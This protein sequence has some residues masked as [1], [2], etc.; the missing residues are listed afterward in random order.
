M[1]RKPI[2]WMVIVFMA[3]SVF[4][5]P[6]AVLAE[7]GTVTDP[8][9]TQESQGSATGEQSGENGG[10]T[11]DPP[12]LTEEPDQ[13]MIQ[14]PVVQEVVAAEVTSSQVFGPPVLKLKSTAKTS[15]KLKW[16]VVKDAKGYVIYR[17]KGKKYVKIKTIKKAKITSYTNKKLKKNKT[18]KYRIKAYYYSDDKKVYSKYSKTLSAKTKSGKIV[19]SAGFWKTNAGK[20]IKKAESKLGARYR[21]GGTGPKSFDCSGFVY[22][23]YKNSGAKVKKVPRMGRTTYSKYKKYNIGRNIKKAKP[24]DIIMFSRSGS[25][26]RITHV[27]IYYGNGKIIHASDYSTGVI[28][29]GIGS[30]KTVAIIRLPGMGAGTGTA[31]SK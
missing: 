15:V 22:W 5:T 16:N 24:G 31:S 13:Q 1:K 12:G 26:K 3:F 4:C 18:Y 2:L 23:V 6:T 11:T 10:E 30:R 7:E 25:V 27:A 19:R 29:G 17:A 14:T 9:T 28:V 20:I 8:Q 21:Y